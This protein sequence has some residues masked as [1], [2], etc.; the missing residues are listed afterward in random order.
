VHRH[1]ETSA[2]A[3]FVGYKPAEVGDPFALEGWLRFLLSFRGCGGR[4]H[5]A[6]GFHVSR[7]GRQVCHRTPSRESASQFAAAPPPVK[8]KQH[9][10]CKGSK[11]D[12]IFGASAEW[13]SWFEMP[14][15]PG[16]LRTG[17]A[18]PRT[19][20]ALAEEGFAQA[21]AKPSGGVCFLVRIERPAAHLSSELSTGLSV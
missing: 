13:P 3:L 19:A 5:D 16:G 4:T 17:I 2:P 18:P 20:R 15:S 6:Q 7:R 8:N 1:F 9:L 12:M 11:S 10:S 14:R 21:S